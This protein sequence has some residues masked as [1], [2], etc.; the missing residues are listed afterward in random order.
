MRNKRKGKEKEMGEKGWGRG[1]GSCRR[2][3]MDCSVSLFAPPL[4]HAPV[5]RFQAP[6]SASTGD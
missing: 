1:K 5:A 4:T 3:D 2:G 6:V